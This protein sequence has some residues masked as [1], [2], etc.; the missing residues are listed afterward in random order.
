MDGRGGAKAESI[1]LVLLGASVN[2]AADICLNSVF[3]VGFV[4]C[5]T[6]CFSNCG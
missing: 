1:S 4:S 2:L 3:S 6:L 5:D